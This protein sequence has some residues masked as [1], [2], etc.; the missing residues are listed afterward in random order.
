TNG[1]P[2]YGVWTSGPTDAW[3]VG[4][5][6]SHWG[7]VSWTKTPPLL[8]GFQK[9][10]GSGPDDVWAVGIP[11]PD[12][13]LAHKDATGWT[14]T[15]VQIGQYANTYYSVWGI[16]SNN[17]WAGGTKGSPGVIIYWN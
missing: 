4:S 15:A 17:I 14:R 1:Q 16:D 12:V 9:V 6:T 3:A 7:G 11:N 5:R 13:N 8:S 2:C 10:W